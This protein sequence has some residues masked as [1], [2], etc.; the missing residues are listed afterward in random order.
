MTNEYTQVTSAN[1]ALHVCFA[2][3][4]MHYFDGKPI[5]ICWCGNWWY[6]DPKTGS[7]K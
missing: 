2:C 1:G 4:W 7:V 3:K 6:T 5:E